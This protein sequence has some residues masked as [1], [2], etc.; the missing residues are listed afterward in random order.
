MQ[1]TSNQIG[2]ENPKPWLE[3]LPMLSDEVCMQEPSIPL[4]ENNRHIQIV[5]EPCDYIGA[6]PSKKTLNVLIDGLNIWYKVPSPQVDIIK[7]VCELLHTV[8][9]VYVYIS[10]FPN[11]FPS[12]SCIRVS[13]VDLKEKNKIDFAD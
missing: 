3:K 13:Y 5:R 1:G 7:P 6:L 12:I 9:L 11:L 8:S 10:C 4:L 2:L